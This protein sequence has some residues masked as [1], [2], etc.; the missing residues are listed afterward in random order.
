MKKSL[1]SALLAS[2]L[3]GAC[4]GGSDDEPVATTPDTVPASATA[5]TQAFASYTGSLPASDTKEPVDIASAV[6]PTS[7]TDEP[8][9]VN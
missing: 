7:E 9:V 2:T 8:I 5:S 4:F 1:A 6:P 3:L